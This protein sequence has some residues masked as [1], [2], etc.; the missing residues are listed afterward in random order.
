MGAQT[1]YDATEEARQVQEFRD[2]F[3]RAGFP[4]RHIERNLQNYETPTDGHRQALEA[5]AEYAES[6][7]PNGRLPG[8]CALFYGPTGTGK[9]HLAVGI[10]K[11]AAV[12]HSVKYATVSSLARAVRSSYSK[13]ATKTED[14]IL[15]AHVAPGLLVLD[16]IGVGSGT[17][18]ERAMMHDVIAGRYDARRPTVFLSN[19]SLPEVKAAL[20]DRVVDRIREDHGIVIGCNW[21]SWRGRL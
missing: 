20:G 13:L 17:D 18:H 7:A 12:R 19:L 11:R 10:A 15:A 21:E 4:E 16:E 9:T 1:C 3:L 8:T 2:R 5:A 14:E 6:M